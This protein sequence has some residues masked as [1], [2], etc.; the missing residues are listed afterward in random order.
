[1]ELETFTP[2][3]TNFGDTLP[4]KDAVDRP[5][6]VLVREHRTGVVTKFKPEG[7]E[8]VVVDVADVKTDEVWLSVLWMNGAIVDN[9]AGYVGKPVAIQI[10]WMASKS[11]GNAYLNV[12]PLEGQVLALAQQWV[13]NNPNRFDLERHKR[14]AQAAELPP[15]TGPGHGNPNNSGAGNGA[16]VPDPNDPLSDPKVQALLAQVAAQHNK[17]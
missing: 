5:L 4:A 17:A 15:G 11:G 2:R 7:G 16:A 9:L 1:M 12:E 14:V 3:E 13:A 10:V 8:A 6:I